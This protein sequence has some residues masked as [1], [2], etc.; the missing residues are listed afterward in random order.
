MLAVTAIGT[1]MYTSILILLCVGFSFT[2]MIEKFPNLAHTSYASIGTM[3]AFT[4]V[5]L[6]GFNPYLA[7]IPAALANGLVGV[8]I[9]ILIVRPMKKIWTG[10]IQ[11]TFAVFALSYII[12]SIILVFSYWL[13]LN[14]RIISR[15]FILQSYD[16][17]WMGLPGIIFVA[18]ITCI[19]LVIFLHL[20]LTRSKFGIAIRATA[21]DPLLATSLGVNITH[22]HIA[23]WFMSGAMA[24]LAGAALPLWQ[25]TVIG[26]SDKLLIDVVAGSVL[27][28]LDNI[29]GAIIGG[30]TL[31][32]I[33]RILPRIV[34]KLF[35][36][37]AAS[38]IGL[39][40][41]IVIVS[42]LIFEP[43]G[44]TSILKKEGKPINRLHRAIKRLI[45]KK[46]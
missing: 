29:Y 32:F 3:F 45:P 43:E 35:G 31:A 26:G 4:L 13:F 20:F 2:H 33:Q 36:I 6:M 44:I 9:Y 38:Y 41:I 42:V 15:G 7:W 1:I 28:G 14:R 27:G 46:D 34:I 10:G 16:F 18:P 8:V 30:I 21:E 25:S 39:V 5:R 19:T 37:W 40:P 17:E 11:I 24:G 23:S 12:N 22:I